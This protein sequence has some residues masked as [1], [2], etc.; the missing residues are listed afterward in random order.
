MNQS[1][2]RGPIA[3]RQKAHLEDIGKCEDFGKGSSLTP[4]RDCINDI[5]TKGGGIVFNIHCHL[6][7]NC[8]LQTLLAIMACACSH[9]Y[10]LCMQP[11]VYVCKVNSRV[12]LFKDDHRQGTVAFVT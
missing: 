12:S 8:H 1:L 3:E 6:A 7:I 10:G 9:M 2:L 5:R 4:A 11:H